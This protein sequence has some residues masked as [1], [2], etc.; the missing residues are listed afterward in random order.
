MGR[1]LEHAMASMSEDIPRHTGRDEARTK[2]R[3]RLNPTRRL[4]RDGLCVGRA[5]RAQPGPTRPDQ[6]GPRILCL[7]P[8]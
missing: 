8:I 1:G 7:P 6:R 5:C 2:D 4:L 3:A